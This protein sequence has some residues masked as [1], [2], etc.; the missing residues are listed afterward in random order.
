VVSAV[1]IK[2]TKRLLLGLGVI[3]L[4]GSVVSVML[5]AAGLM[6]LPEKLFAGESTV[7]TVARLA[8]IGCLLAAVGSHE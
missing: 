8:V 5:M 6:Q 1:L 4:I 2:R 3:L 7:H